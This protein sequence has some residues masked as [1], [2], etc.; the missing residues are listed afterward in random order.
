VTYR[1]RRRLEDILAATAA[2]RSH[3]SRGALTDGLV[4]DGVRIRLLEIGEAV[5]ALPRDLLQRRPEIPWS[6]IARMR[7]HLAHRYFDTTHAILQ[8]TVENDLPDLERAVRALLDELP[9]DLPDD[10]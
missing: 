6:E 4:F 9:S 8:A 5:K 2:I 10:G 3:L 1:D 7:D